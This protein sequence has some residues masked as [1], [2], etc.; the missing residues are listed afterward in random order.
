MCSSVMKP[1][2]TVTFF[3]LFVSALS[4][5]NDKK[6]TY[7]NQFAVHI[8]NATEILVQLIADK[9]GFRSLGQIG[10]LD[11]Y[12]LFEHDRIHKRSTD[13]S[14]YHN[15]KLVS[16]PG[17]LWVEQQFEKRRSKRDFASLFRPLLQQQSSRARPFDFGK[18]N[19]FA[20]PLYNQQWH[21]HGENARLNTFD[22]NVLPAWNKGYSG[23]GI[24]V[25]ILDDGIQTNHPDLAQNYDPLASTDINDNDNDPMPRDNGDNKHGTRCAGE[26]AAVAS[27]SVCGVGIAFNASI[28]GVR[29][30]DGTVNDVVEARALSLNP[31]HIDIYSASWG[32]EDDGKT[33]DGPGTLAKRAFING[34]M[35]GRQGKGSIFVWASGNGG[36]FEDSCNCDGYTNSIFTLS[37]SSA[38]QAGFK[39]WYL[40]ECSSTL[41]TTYSSGRPGVDRSVTTVDMD[42]S[43]RPDFLCTS[44]HTGTSASAPLAAGICALALEA[45]P[46]LTWRDM[47][48]LVVFT[49]RPD[50]LPENGWI[51][52]GIGRK[53]SHKFGYGLMDAGAMV[54]LAEQ[55]VNVPLQHVCQ[56]PVDASDRIIPNGNG[57]K[58][59]VMVLTDACIGTPH[60]IR[61]LEHV[62]CRISLRFFPRGNLRMRLTSPSG[63]PSVLLF[64]RPRDMLESSFEDWP[65]MTVHFWGERAAGTWKLEV[66]NAGNKRVNQPGILKKFQLVFYGTSTNPVRLQNPTTSVTGGGGVETTATFGRDIHGSPPTPFG[67]NGDVLQLAGSRPV[68]IVASPQPPTPSLTATQSSMIKDNLCRKYILNK[69]CVD[70]C[71]SLGYYVDIPLKE[72]KQCHSSCSKCTGSQLDH[73]LVCAPGFLQLMDKNICVQQCPTSYHLDQSR[74][75]CMP[76][77]AQCNECNSLL[78]CTKCESRLML[79]QGRCVSSCSPAHFQTDDYECLPCSES[80]SSCSGNADHCVSCADSYLEFNQTCVEQCPSGFWNDSSRDQCLPCPQ[81][82]EMCSW[83]D[84]EQGLV[85]TKCALPWLLDVSTQQCINPSS[86]A[87]ST[88]EYFAED[89]CIECHTSC[90]QCV[91]PLANDCTECSPEMS[92]MTEEGSCIESCPQATFSETGY[93]SP[94]QFCVPCPLACAQCDALDHCTECLGGLHLQGGRCLANCNDGYYSD[95][96]VCVPC[97]ES[98]AA[99]SGPLSTDCT[100]CSAGLA[101]LQ[102]HCISQCPAGFYNI[103]TPLLK[104]PSTV[105]HLQ[106]VKCSA[107]CKN[108]QL[109]HATDI[110][111]TCLECSQEYVLNNDNSCV[112]RSVN[113][114]LELPK[115]GFVQEG[116]GRGA[117]AGIRPAADAM[118]S[119]E[120]V[121]YWLVGMVTS[122]FILVGVVV[123]V[124]TKLADNSSGYARLSALSDQDHEIEGG[125]LLLLSSS[126][127]EDEEHDIANPKV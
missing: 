114:K 3:C 109:L 55:W 34:I 101:W 82:C 20:D 100:S 17:V 18:G 92:W 111:A 64:E 120:S 104:K 94:F 107:S 1:V 46:S 65:F 14:T 103:S 38:T 122:I 70:D 31:N 80:C 116:E 91:G 81:G 32:P 57:Q 4:A 41:A 73:C 49:S 7:N 99:C 76:C 77:P 40:E 2:F 72:C 113:N 53:V 69:T 10:T 110:Q 44:E 37:I 45:N 29:M 88:G 28:G 119:I 83:Q 96:G 62:Q 68:T 78:E 97:H 60:E 108:C 27:N 66:I 85:C 61:F 123:L 79:V 22:M 13:P 26:V 63:T 84:N 11:G 106:C 115:V 89:E 87:C 21:L 39:P 93:S 19:E 125:K 9:H 95:R 16:E 30:L 117:R 15:G 67:A 59:E 52:N 124:K 36:R 102:Q 98:C 56:T 6:L 48:H 118:R 127:I 35:K 51:T 71:P 54:T 43:L 8:P 25:S 50:P 42:G 24:V 58:L 33:V 126:D 74:R 105:S 86:N 112:P 90:H 121:S 75:V 12:F 5:I 23:K 47:Q